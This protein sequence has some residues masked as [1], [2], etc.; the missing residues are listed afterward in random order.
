M[1]YEDSLKSPPTCLYLAPC[2][3]MF[4]VSQTILFD[5][6]KD[7]IFLVLEATFYY[8]FYNLRSQHDCFNRFDLIL[9]IQT[10]LLQIRVPS[11]P[12]TIVAQQLL[13]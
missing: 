2:L 5:F 9:D 7:V 12:M 6:V 1:E 4:F 10:L 8:L 11:Y 3:A 13:E